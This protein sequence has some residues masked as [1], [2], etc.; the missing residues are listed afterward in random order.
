M[1]WHKIVFGV[2]V[3]EE[4]WQTDDQGETELK[5][6]SAARKKYIDAIK[7]VIKHAGKKNYLDPNQVE[8]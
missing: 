5:P 4:D 3:T 6:G 7:M 1:N 2:F 8:F